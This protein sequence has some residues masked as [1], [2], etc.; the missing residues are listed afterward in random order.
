MSSS[1]SFRRGHSK[2]FYESDKW[3]KTNNNNKSEDEMSD[4]EARTSFRSVKSA[5][6]DDNSASSD[7]DLHDKSANLNNIPSSSRI[8]SG[9]STFRGSH[10]LNNRSVE[11]DDIL[12]E[13]TDTDESNPPREEDSSHSSPD[14]SFRL[15]SRLSRRSQDSSTDSEKDN[16]NKSKKNN[17]QRPPSTSNSKLVPTLSHKS[18]DSGFSDSAESNFQCGNESSSSS[19]SSASPTAI[20]KDEEDKE[21]GGRGTQ[22]HSEVVHETR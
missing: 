22:V 19:C 5:K 10:S 18:H 21:N 16:N 12:E 14:C 6:E 17:S 2:V 11:L 8:L 9:G 7:E 13:E 15:N 4:L 3:D 20:T 1:S